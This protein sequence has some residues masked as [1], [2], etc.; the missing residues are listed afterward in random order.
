MKTVVWAGVLRRWARLTSFALGVGSTRRRITD[1][2]ATSMLACI[3]QP[4]ARPLPA[5]SPI[6]GDVWD[7]LADTGAALSSLFVV[8]M[9]FTGERKSGTYMSGFFNAASALPMALHTAQQP[10]QFAQTTSRALAG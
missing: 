9:L 10:A 2:L 3:A 7:D 1:A 4:A 5:C 6:M 8:A